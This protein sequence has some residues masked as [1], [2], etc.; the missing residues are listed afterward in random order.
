MADPS[1]HGESVAEEDSNPGPRLSLLVSLLNHM[2]SFTRLS[3][4]LVPLGCRLEMLVRTTRGG[5]LG[6]GE[7]LQP[8]ASFFPG[9]E[10]AFLS[11]Y[12]SEA[13]HFSWKMLV[14]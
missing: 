10:R 1:S 7:A 2:S 11:K 13:D 8:Q 9:L 14:I 3:V 5:A 6:Q 12:S 4:L